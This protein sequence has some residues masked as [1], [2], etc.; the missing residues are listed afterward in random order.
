MKIKHI[1][2]NASMDQVNMSLPTFFRVRDVLLP[3]ELFLF[4]CIVLK[5]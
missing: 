2:S 5:R 4:Y 3:N 1:A